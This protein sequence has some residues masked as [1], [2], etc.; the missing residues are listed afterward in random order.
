[1]SDCLQPHGLQPTRLLCPWNSLGKNPGLGV[2]IP[3]SMGSSQPRDQIWISLI[4]GRFSTI[5][6]TGEA[7]KPRAFLYENYACSLLSPQAS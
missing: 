5:W 7:Q 2:T 3:F 4:A 1:M 6:A